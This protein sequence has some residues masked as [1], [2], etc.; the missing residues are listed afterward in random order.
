MMPLGAPL[1]ERQL[2]EALR[3]LATWAMEL[4]LLCMPWM[5]VVLFGVLFIRLPRDLPAAAPAQRPSEGGLFP[6]EQRSGGEEEWPLVSVIIP[7]R[8]EEENIGTCVSSVAGSQYP[9]F[10]IIVVDD[11]SRDRTTEIVQGLSRGN[12]RRI[13]PVRGEP[14]PEGWFGK[15]WA[16]HQ[17][18]SH[19]TG[20]LLLFTDADTV[21][22]P[23]LLERAVRGLVAGD[24]HALTLVG[25]Q[26][27][28]TF[29]EQ[30]LQPQFFVLLAFR[31]PR[32]SVPRTKRHWR[33]AIA[34]GQ[35][36]LFRRRVYD[37]L[38]GHEAV[39]GEVVEDIRLAQVLALGG[40]RLV[41]RSGE[42]FRTRMYRS[43]GGLVEGWSKNISTGA[44]QTTAGWLQPLILPLSLLGGAG[45]FILP[46]ATLIWA[47]LAGTG[48]TTLLWA[49]LTT[50][51]GVLFWSLASW[52]MKGNPLF[53]FLFPLGAM[54]SGFIIVKSWLR[55]GN[56]R[57]KG[58][59]YRM[60]PETRRGGPVG[61]LQGRTT[62]P[63]A[64]VPADEAGE[65]D[66]T[67][68]KATPRGGPLDGS[69]GQDPGRP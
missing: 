35:Y 48:G 11:G 17:G 26:V 41:V 46:P 30:L 51:L 12:A 29:W 23:T 10:E 20:E 69:S 39:A 44:L 8:D 56:I 42:G 54:M 37:A 9:A 15:P 21:H 66:V 27:M 65:G 45:L 49:A 7:A 22:D 1:A 28:G 4:L 60:T 36:M 18:A 34:N 13:L 53:G 14:L 57:W 2:P 68:E 63:G 40:W 55:G 24:A 52:V 62:P 31:F 59:A 67:R 25:R 50:G 47:L 64:R 38:G 32:V 3:P 19:A 33:H 61:G 5:A 58:R 43:L 6:E 16:C